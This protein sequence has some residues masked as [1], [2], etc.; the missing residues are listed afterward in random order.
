MATESVTSPSV[1]MST[2]AIVTHASS[3]MITTAQGHSGH[4]HSN[5]GQAHTPGQG[6]QV[7]MGQV[8]PNQGHIHPSH[9]HP[10]HIHPSYIHPSYIHPSYIHPSY[11]HTVRV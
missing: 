1:G 6:H 7:H 4:I 11:I 3:A 9:I 8:H 5:P 2:S 10:S